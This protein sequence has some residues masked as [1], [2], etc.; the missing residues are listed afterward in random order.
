MSTL[1]LSNFY[2]SV[3]IAVYGREKKGAKIQIKMIAYV[4]ILYVSQRITVF[5]Q[6]D[7]FPTHRI[8]DDIP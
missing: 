6:L 1:C 8:S 2:I 5:S 7:W 3:I 4:A